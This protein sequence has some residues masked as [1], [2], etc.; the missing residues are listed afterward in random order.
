VIILAID[1]GAATASAAVLGD[2][3]AAVALSTRPRAHAQ[4]LPAL[5]EEAVVR[6]GL[7]R[8][9]ITHVAAARGPGLFT[10]MRVGLVT[11]QMI[12]LAR[13]LPV[14]GISSLAA[15]ALRVQQHHRPTTPYAV[16]LDARRREVFAQVFD[17]DAA[18]VSEPRTLALE[19][20][21]NVTGAGLPVAD[22]A[23]WVDQAAAA[24]GFPGHAMEVSGL[25]A[26]VA[27]VA[28]HRWL[29]G[30]AQEP[31]TPLYL[32]RPDTSSANPQ[33]SVLGQR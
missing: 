28:R 19:A 14:A 26:E 21:R 1:T 5:I 13:D 16:L 31:P 22:D 33:R 20:A 32:R 4:V 7:S 30:A 24:L 27:A 9:A 8:D 23:I 12:G 29:Q 17:P 11:A 18:P 2:G 25:A 15:A 6:A 10:G 3:D